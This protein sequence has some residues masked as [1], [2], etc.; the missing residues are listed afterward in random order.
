M[1]SNDSTHINWS[2]TDQCS[3]Q[4][5]TMDIMEDW[6]WK[7]MEELSPSATFCLYNRITIELTRKA[8]FPILFLFYFFYFFSHIFL[9][10]TMVDMKNSTPQNWVFCLVSVTGSNL[11]LGSGLDLGLELGSDLGLGSVLCVILFDKAVNEKKK[12]DGQ[13]F[14]V[15][16][17]KIAV[18]TFLAILDQKTPFS[19]SCDPRGLLLLLLSFC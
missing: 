5:A 7:V 6:R 8:I 3:D 1:G 15:L 13:F 12:Q 19:G 17:S 4:K 10:K 16:F 14:W 2:M 11:G 18:F 9:L